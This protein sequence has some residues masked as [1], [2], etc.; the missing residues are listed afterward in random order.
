MKRNL[1]YVLS[2][3]FLLCLVYACR[4]DER[5]LETRLP[6][7][8]AEMAEWYGRQL[9]PNEN[10]Q[11]FA[12]MNK[13]D[14]NGTV[15]KKKG[16]STLYTTL[17]LTD[18]KS[19]RELQVTYYDGSYTGLVRQ[20]DFAREDSTAVGTFTINGRMLDIG[21]F[22][23]KNR[24]VLKA[25]TNK[26]NIVLMGTEMGGELPEVVVTRPWP[27]TPG[28]GTIIGTP[29][30][31][32]F[33]PIIGGG[34]Y[35]GTPEPTPIEIIFKCGGDNKQFV[36][37]VTKALNELKSGI[38]SNYT[39]SPCFMA[40]FFKNLQQK[41]NG[42]PLNICLKESPTGANGTYSN[43]TVGFIAGDYVSNEVFFHELIH[44]YQ[45]I[46]GLYPNFSSMGGNSK[47]FANIEFE[48]QLMTDL[49]EGI[50]DGYL[51]QLDRTLF[52][53][54]EFD[55]LDE[56]YRNWFKKFYDSNGNFKG[57][58]VFNETGVMDGYYNYLKIYATKSK[59][60]KSE[61]FDTLKPLALINMLSTAGI[62]CK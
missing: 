46:S 14:W 29:T 7:D 55:V 54:A 50:G 11:A 42:N 32:T 12:N 8:V 21:Y 19:T 58:E 56:S 16:D 15:V 48:T 35:P 49:V 57:A 44:Y 17:I 60:Y 3:V 53:T 2:A 62:N 45:N 43:N 6:E 27:G 25:V 30:L 61:I 10:P 33:P 4:K 23:G 24:Y 22:D 1:K 51:N 13:P 18:A 47:G 38:M 9:L 34:T 41:Q 36:D 59:Y 40:A 20:Y 5:I 37:L 31:P 39:V 28:T 26:R 52:T